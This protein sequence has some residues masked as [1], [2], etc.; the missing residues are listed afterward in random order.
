MRRA[1][2]FCSLRNQASYWRRRIPGSR[3]YVDFSLGTRDWRVA[4][5]L[6]CVLTL[7]S[8]RAFGSLREGNMTEE[9]VKAFMKLCFKKHQ[10]KLRSLTI[11]RMAP[12]SKQT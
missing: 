3:A 7:E 10:D 6:S 2:Q 11:H 1:V 8:E 5:Q 9:Q 4:Q 12:S